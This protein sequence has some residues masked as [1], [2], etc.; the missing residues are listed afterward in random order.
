[1]VHPSPADGS[2]DQMAHTLLHL[3]QKQGLFS[4]TG[5]AT[6]VKKVFQQLPHDSLEKICDLYVDQGLSS[7][8]KKKNK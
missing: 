8:D 2:N 4:D 5:E 6:V 7:L 3:F 1:M